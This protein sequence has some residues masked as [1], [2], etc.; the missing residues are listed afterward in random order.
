VQEFK[1]PVEG[2][3]A[4]YLYSTVSLDFLKFDLRLWNSVHPM[5]HAVPQK[6]VVGGGWGSAHS[7]MEDCQGYS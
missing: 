3:G 2:V 1:Y 7:Q 4:V 6:G 5:T